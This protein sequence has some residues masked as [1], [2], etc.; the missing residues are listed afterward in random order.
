[1]WN[2]RIVWQNCFRKTSLHKEIVHLKKIYKDQFD[3][4]KKTRALSKEHDDSLI[5]QLNSKSLENTD[6]KRQIQD[7]IDLDPLAPSL[8]QNRDARIYY[9]KYTHKQADILRGIV[10]QAK[11]KQPLDNALDFA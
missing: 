7:K 11:A 6:L 5:T 8:L 3:S 10:K 1:M 4:I 9:L 2:W